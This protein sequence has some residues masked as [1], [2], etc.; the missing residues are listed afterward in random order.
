MIM[1]HFPKDDFIYANAVK[2]CNF[3]DMYF[4]NESCLQKFHAGDVKKASIN[5]SSYLELQRKKKKL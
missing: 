2:E 3:Q 5:V 4:I 1:L